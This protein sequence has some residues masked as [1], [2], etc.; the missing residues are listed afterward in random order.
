MDVLSTGSASTQNNARIFSGSSSL[1]GDSETDRSEAPLIAT[2]LDG[3]HNW[4]S[5]GMS[6]QP[7]ELKMEASKGNPF[8]KEGKISSS[9]V[10][11]A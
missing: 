8:E 11:V 9:K 6:I 4:P 3:Q 2:V 1:P 7:E 10:C 5:T